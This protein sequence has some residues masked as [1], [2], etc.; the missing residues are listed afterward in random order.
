MFRSVLFSLWAAA[1]DVQ[2]NEDESGDD[3]S[4]S[5]EEVWICYEEE[6]FELIMLVWSNG[7]P[8]CLFY[9]VV[10]WFFVDDFELVDSFFEWC[11][12]RIENT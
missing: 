3:G 10:S 8:L 1:V 4:E 9:E 11:L 6:S 7:H 2:H 5:A 12:N